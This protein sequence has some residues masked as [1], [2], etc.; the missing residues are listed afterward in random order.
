MGK[1]F[2]Q[3][4]FFEGEVVTLTPPAQEVILLPLPS[5][6]WSKESL[7]SLGYSVDQAKVLCAGFVLIRMH[8]GINSISHTFTNPHNRWSVAER[9]NSF[10]QMERAFKQ[11]L[12]RSNRIATNLAG[13]IFIGMGNRNKLYAAGFDFYRLETDTGGHGQNRIKQGRHNWSNYTKADTATK[14]V[15]AWK[16]LMTEPKALEG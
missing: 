5:E 8:P 6:V 9:Y 13:D 12:E 2:A 11:E 16:Q 10:A 1:D 7:V 3:M 4:S 15:A 14:I